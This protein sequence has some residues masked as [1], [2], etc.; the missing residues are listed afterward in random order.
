LAD[1]THDRLHQD[2][3]LAIVPDT[4]R[5]MRAALDAG[6]WASWLSGSGPSMAC[7]C[8]TARVEQVAASLPREGQVHRLAIDMNGPIAS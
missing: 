2:V 7:L 4:K 3:R 6:A 1:A 5:A 8:D